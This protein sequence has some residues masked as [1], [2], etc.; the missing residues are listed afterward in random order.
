VTPASAIEDR[1]NLRRSGENNLALNSLK[2]WTVRLAGRGVR[3]EQVL[4]DLLGGH[5]QFKHRLDW[6]L[7]SEAPHFFDFRSGVFALAFGSAPPS[8][9]TLDRAAMARDAMAEGDRV[10]DIGC[11]DGFFTRRFYCDRAS[12]IDAIDIEPSAI[13]HAERYHAHP[14]INYVETD[15]VSKPFPASQYDAIVWNGALGHF[16]EADTATML[17]KIRASLTPSGVFVGSESLGV[18]GH[19]HYQYF[20]DEPTVQ[21]LFSPYFRY[22]ATRV[23]KYTIGLQR[24]FERREVFWRCSDTRESLMRDAWTWAEPL[25][26]ASGGQKR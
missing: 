3:R 22:V 4:V 25:V 24:N 9:H 11:G 20:A 8:S 6:D 12:R 7:S 17:Q 16:S 10:L 19:D 26:E 14:K 15:A 21:K 2:D 23:V 18:E 1:Y 13:S 5:F